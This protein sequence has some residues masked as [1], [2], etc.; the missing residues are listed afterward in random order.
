MNT[1]LVAGK[2]LVAVVVFHMIPIR[3]FSLDDDNEED[4]SG[5]DS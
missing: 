5:S 4:D 3:I 2:V 1:A